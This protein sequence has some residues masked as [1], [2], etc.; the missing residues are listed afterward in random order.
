VSHSHGHIESHLLA[1]HPELH[2]NAES[3]E[4][5]AVASLGPTEVAAWMITTHSLI[6]HAY[7]FDE[8]VTAIL[9]HAACWT[10]VGREAWRNLARPG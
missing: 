4:A 2:D 9:S 5:I 8:A 6:S 1:N 7:D 3:L 10:G